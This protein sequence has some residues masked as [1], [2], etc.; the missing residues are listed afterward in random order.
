MDFEQIKEKVTIRDILKEQGYFAKKNR[1]RCP[2]H[3]GDNPTSF[4]FTDQVFYCHSCGA[5]GGLID[6]TEALLKLDRP[7]ALRYL[8]GLAGVRYDLKDNK[9]RTI[10]SRK[11][12]RRIIDVRLSKLEKSLKDL[13]IQRKQ[14]TNR[15]LNARKLYKS[16]KLDLYHCSS[17]VQN[18]DYVL[19]EL[20][21]EVIETIYEIHKRRNEIKDSD[22]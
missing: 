13:E 6:L 1:M 3:H 19:E 10:P 21:A 17:I 14:Y 7:D 16:S 9:N 20:D 12:S 2:I 4:V 15:I 11:S 5:S 8:A 18:A 22:K